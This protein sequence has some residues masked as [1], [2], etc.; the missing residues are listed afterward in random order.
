MLAGDILD[1]QSAR[2]ALAGGVGSFFESE[3]EAP[4][5]VTGAAPI[6][7]D[8]VLEG[9]IIAGRR[10]DY[11]QNLNAL[12]ERYGAD[13]TVFLGNTRVASTIVD[14]DGNLVI[15]TVLEN[16]EIYQ[17][18]MRG[19]T[20][21]GDAFVQGERFSAFYMPIKDH[22]GQAFGIIFGGFSM[23][24][25]IA[26]RNAM[27][28]EIILLSALVSAISL[29]FLTFLMSKVLGPVKAL[30]R[31]VNDVS[32]GKLNSNSI[33]ITNDE[34]GVL[35]RDV[36]GLVGVIRGIITDIS[37]FINQTS[38][39]GDIDYRIDES[40][41]NGSYKEII[42]GINNY[43]EA[44]VRDLKISME[45][46]GQVSNG[47][48]NLKIPELPGKKVALTNAVRKLAQNLGDIDA[49]ITK[50]ANAA[51]AGELN[52]R[53][54]NK[55]EGS[56]ASLIGDMNNL[57]QSV[58]LPLLEIENAL[59]DI[60]KGSFDKSVRG[61][62][63]GSFKSLADAANKTSTATNEVI[64]DISHILAN[65][66]EGDL[67]KSTQKEYIGE[68][69]VIKTAIDGILS[70]LNST[71]GEIKASAESVS[72]G[73][74]Y[75]AEN[76]Q[77]LAEGS[78]KQAS[79]VEQLAATIEQ[80]KERSKTSTNA[81]MEVSSLSQKSRDSAESGSQDMNAMVNTMEE[82]RMASSNIARII[83]VIEEISFQTNLLALNAAVEAA[84]AGEHGKGFGVVAEEVRSLASR[85]QTAVKE[86]SQEI[87]QSVSTVDN[88]VVAVQSV[89]SSLGNIV[90]Y[91]MEVSQHIN[92]I[93]EMSHE[94]SEAISQINEGIEDISQ[95]VASNTAAS[96]EFAA[97]SQELNALAQSLQELVKF[98]RL[99]Y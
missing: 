42:E 38:N 71:L 8:G 44:S 18:V 15:G 30:V 11:S 81:A 55:Y 88:G 37:E 20:Y 77:T 45:I 47:D 84:R 49:D 17:T 95:V 22:T 52:V 56:W 33:R 29:F 14:Q 5:S 6:F 48:F 67:T 73:S 54:Q 69:A 24:G 34:L 99:S 92:K 31:L 21:T 65:I 96:E 12:K 9:A 74:T 62:Y 82:I 28:T 93:T 46:V 3:P 72:D 2:L 4:I 85:S 59:N 64:Q 35:T 57:M 90:G 40:G 19:Q 98:F 23:S 7:I 60:S 61:E 39:N 89:S 13:F 94:T 32:K 78:T 70:S 76:A 58:A 87:G 79:A 97:A 66:A 68:Y 25:H 43:A 27:V 63:R 16:Q 86:T 41:Y 10:L 75:V 26:E 80:L 50:L 36:Q 83:K 51:A 91:V 1:S 53:A